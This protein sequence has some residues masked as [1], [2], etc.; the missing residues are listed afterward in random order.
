MGFFDR[1]R[2]SW[3]LFKVALNFL[4]RDKSLIAVP[5]LLPIV[6][7]VVFLLAALWVL[8]N[9]GGPSLPFFVV[10]IF[11]SYLASTFLKAAHSWMVY[12]VAL[13]KNTTLASGLR[14]AF[15][16]AADVLWFSLVMTVISIIAGAI[17]GKGGR[18]GASMLR[19]A[20]AGIIDFLTSVMG[21]LVLPAMIVTNK[22]FRESVED[23]RSLSKVLPEA[24]LLEAGLGPLELAAFVVVFF[25]LLALAILSM[26]VLPM[27]AFWTMITFVALTFV[28]IIALNILKSFVEITYYTLLYLALVKKRKIKGVKDVF[29]LKF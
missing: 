20:T 23:V 19:G 11:V 6:N 4:R 7:L 26:T 28:L 9:F 3:S 24:I 22:T 17:R 10:V 16:N 14:R 25:P 1:L 12:E 2:N 13:G 21:K 18:G 29:Y 8:A 27:F 5:I 15:Q